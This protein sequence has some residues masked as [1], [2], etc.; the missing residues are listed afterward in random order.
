MNTTETHINREPAGSTCPDCGGDVL[1]LEAEDE[2]AI[3]GACGQVLRESEQA[4][5]A[6]RDEE[7]VSEDSDPSTTRDWSEQYAVTN[8]TEDQVATAFSILEAIGD[9]LELSREA[10]ANA[11][12]VYSA[13]AKRT[14]TTGRP[15]EETVAAA[16]HLG[17]QHAGEPRPLAAVAETG[18]T[19]ESNLCRVTKRLRRELDEQHAG[20]QPAEYLPYLCRTFD[21]PQSIA[22]DARDLVEQATTTGTFGGCSPPGVAGAALYLAADGD[23]TQRAIARAAGV[24]TETIRVRLQDLRALDGDA[25]EAGSGE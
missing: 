6:S 24:T 25:T 14:L 17:A 7:P 22:D 3:C 2:T 23:L 16:V 8:S 19:Q 10:R 20:S 12:A 4:R 1:P 13:A 21:V 9:D 11:A 15:L 5:A 18:Q